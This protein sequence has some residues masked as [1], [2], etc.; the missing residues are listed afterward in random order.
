[1]ALPRQRSSS[2]QRLWNRYIHLLM[3]SSLGI[4]IESQDIAFDYSSFV[5]HRTLQRR[6]VHKK[7]TLEKVNNN[8]KIIVQK[9]M[10]VAKSRY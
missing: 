2:H 10:R 8:T 7:S 3:L 9:V 4:L 5:Y 1:M 6:A